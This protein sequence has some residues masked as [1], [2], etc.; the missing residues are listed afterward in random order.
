[1]HGQAGVQVSSMV[2]SEIVQGPGFNP[3]HRKKTKQP[4]VNQTNN[5][6]IYRKSPL[7]F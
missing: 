3:K 6:S 1:M 5:K 7:K 4:T 2:L